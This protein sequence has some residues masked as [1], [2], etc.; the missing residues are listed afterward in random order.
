MNTRRR[1]TVVLVLALALATLMA[2]ACQPVHWPPV[3]G[4]VNPTG[5]LDSVSGDEGTVR[6]TGWVA[7]FADFGVLWPPTKIMLMVNGEWVPQAF[8]A[9]A[10]RPDVTVA[11]RALALDGFTRPGD[12]YGFDITVPADPGEVTVC[13]VAVNQFRDA[14]NTNHDHVLMGCR[15]VTVT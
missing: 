2:G 15:T 3:P 6:V 9:N 1:Y 7:E 8:E 13:V 10:P 4:E 11:L 12:P 5:V 14:I